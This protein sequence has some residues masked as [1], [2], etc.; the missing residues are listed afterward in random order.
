MKKKSLNK[1]NN[2]LKQARSLSRAIGAFNACNLESLKAIAQAASRLNQPV[3]IEASSREIDYFGL[4]ELAC[5]LNIWRFRSP[6]LLF[7]N[8]DHACDFEMIIRAI[9]LNFDLIHFDGSNLDFEENIK[10]TQKIVA[11]AHQK[12]I[13]VEGEFNRIP[14]QSRNH[15]QEKLNLK[16]FAMT[17]PTQA[18]DFVKRTQIDI[19]AVF[20]GNVHGVYRQ[21]IPLNFDLLA[22][23]KKQLPKTYLSLH[24]GSGIADNHLKKAIKL[25]INKINVNTELRLAYKQALKKACQNKEWAIY[26]YM[27]PVI[28]A[29]GKVV[30][31]KIKLFSH[32]TTQT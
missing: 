21:K 7:L 15:P 13:L 31:E 20:I 18:L 30:E 16:S 6:V 12:N 4:E 25:G 10:M 1:L 14:G 28:E 11:R 26:K 19:L 29:M 32:L 9:D 23:I 17:D 22:K 24:G 3:I 8:L 27:P 5:W 2:Y